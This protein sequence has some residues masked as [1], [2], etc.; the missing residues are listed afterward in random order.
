LSVAQELIDQGLRVLPAG[1]RKKAPIVEW[2]RYQDLSPTVEEYRSW[3]PAGRK[4]NLWVLCGKASGVVV[5]DVDSVGG[6]KF[7]RGQL[8]DE[9]LD[10]TACSQTSKGH[11]YWFRLPK[12]E[13][14][15]SWSWHDGDV[16]FDVRADDTGVIVPPSTHE[17]GFVYTWIRPLS[18]A[19]PWP[20]KAID[21]AHESLRKAE[22]QRTGTE[23]FDEPSGTSSMLEHLLASPPSAGGRNVWLSKVLG[24]LAKMIPYQGA[25]LRLAVIIN[26]GL[27]EPLEQAEL[28]KTCRSIWDSEQEKPTNQP[29]AD[30]GWLMSGEDHLVSIVVVNKEEVAKPIS[31]FDIQVTGKML[32]DEHHVSYRVNLVRSRGG[33]VETVVPAVTFSSTR[34][35]DKWLAAYGVAI[36]PQRNDVCTWPAYKR[37]L[38][39][40]EAQE[41]PTFRAVDQLGWNVEVGGFITHEGILVPGKGLQPHDDVI[42]HPRLVGWAPY[43]YGLGDA[44][45]AREI[46]NQVLT[47]HDPTVCSVY[48]AWWA[49]CFLKAQIVNQTSLFPFLAM[50]AP[51][52]S[53]KTTGFFSLMLQLNGNYEGHGEYTIPVL[54]DRVSANRSGIVWIDDMTNVEAVFDLLRQATSEGSRSKKGMD[55]TVN[56]SVQMVAP[57]AISAEGLGAL[58]LEKALL[59]RSVKLHVPSPVG[60][61]SLITPGRP[62]WDDIV[63]LRQRHP[64]LTEYAGTLT[65]AALECIPMLKELSGLREGAGRWADKMAILRLGARILAKLTGDN[66]HVVRVDDWVLVETLAAPG[67]YDNVLTLQVLP[68]WFAL[69]I[70]L[71]QESSSGGPVAFMKDRQIYYHEEALADWWSEYGR[72]HALGTRSAQLGS[73]SS[74][75]AQR[76]ALGVHDSVRLDV[77]PKT[78]GREQRRYWP[79]SIE[80]STQVLDRASV[81][82]VETTLFPT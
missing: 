77:R 33:T 17:T 70:E 16:S 31:D 21:T 68:T 52:E 7:W 62:Q 14:C 29:S 74:I 12:G 67:K 66:E 5:I 45:K 78:N 44:T 1:F 11:H 61:Q 48:G 55:R 10:S 76:Q 24:H 46:L 81:G 32:N 13:G 41:A 2:K 43:R 20:Q 19:V 51:S 39:Y 22:G 56:E 38:A 28:H 6:D 73:L 15:K 71:L 63:N 8:G 4:N 47:F 60:R 30:N 23:T 25:Y 79:L 37:L 34:D 3:F 27:S 54:R 72:R 49:A 40:I 57:I 80:V 36:Q 18:S 26:N 64:Q 82:L 53:G 9:L 59:D 69:N 65:L 75:R 42:P 35:C 58:S 50:E